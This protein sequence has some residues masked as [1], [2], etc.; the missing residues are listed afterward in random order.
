MLPNSPSA[1]TEYPRTQ[2]VITND[3]SHQ[4][5]TPCPSGHGARRGADRS[6]SVRKVR[7]LFGVREGALACD[8]SCTMQCVEVE[9]FGQ[10]DT[11]CRSVTPQWRHIRSESEAFGEPPVLRHARS[12]DAS[13]S[14]TSSECLQIPPASVER[15]YPNGREA[16]RRPYRRWLSEV[17]RS[18]RRLL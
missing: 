13:C 5:R 15:W 9:L 12:R 16:P 7:L 18:S 6:V 1:R 17:S 4:R 14:T 3:T 8:A 10:N 2:T 11:V